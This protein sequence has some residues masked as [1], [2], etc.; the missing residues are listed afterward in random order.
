VV[1]L[2]VHRNIHAQSILNFICARIA[3]HME[4][5][6]FI[7]NPPSYLNSLEWLSD[8]LHQQP[9]VYGVLVKEKD[10]A[11]L[12]TF[13]QDFPVNR[14]IELCKEKKEFIEGDLLFECK[15]IEPLPLRRL[16]VLVAIDVSENQSIFRFFVWVR[17]IVLSIAL[18]IF[19]ISWLY[20]KRLIMKEERLRR[21]LDATEKLALTGKL[22]SM[23]AHEI[24]SPLNTI[25]MALQYMQELKQFDSEFIKLMRE[26]IKKLEELH[27]ELFEIQ[28]S[29]STEFSE[30]SLKEMISEIETKFNF[31]AQQSGIDFKCD[32]MPNDVIVKGDKRWLT[33]ALENLIK[34]A[35]E[36]V[37]SGGMVE[38]IVKKDKDNLL[39]YVKDNG[40]GLEKTEK[41]IIFEPFYTKKEKGLGLGLYIVKKVA[42]AHGGYISVSS[43]RG[44]GT[45]FQLIIPLYMEE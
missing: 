27:L 2:R 32:I 33:R 38:F 17:S 3:G 29:F 40:K 4:L 45:I 37:E 10:I 31:K 43:E 35:F 28:K 42:E 44:K 21:R 23:I 24:R 25:S 14:Y 9:M 30:F 8:E 7:N 1:I 15:T 19:A 34:N 20:L 12:N 41:E 11:L 39:F 18:L 5:L 26:E 6:K 16:L 36:A 22:S 13:P